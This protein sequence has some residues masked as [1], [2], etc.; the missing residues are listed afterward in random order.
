MQLLGVF[1]LSFATTFWQVLLA[2]GVCMGIANGLL[3][4]PSLSLIASYFSK[5]RGLAMGIAGAGSSTGG[6]VFS[7]IFRQLLPRVGFGWA[8]R[9]MGFVVLACAGVCL[10]G[11]RVRLFPRKGG[12]VLDLAAFKEPPYAILSVALGMI[13]LGVRGRVS[14]SFGMAAQ[15]TALT[16]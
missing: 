9:C 4:V 10:G 5:R 15:L 2:Q 8:C 13:Y 14:S 16:R 6:V 12:P 7:V 1:T 3:F 11:T